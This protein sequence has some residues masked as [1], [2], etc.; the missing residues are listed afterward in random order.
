MITELKPYSE[1]TDSRVEWLGAGR[2]AV[3]Q[4]WLR[5]ATRLEQ[6]RPA[7]VPTVCP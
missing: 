7:C 4:L 6:T 3:G 1:Y 5:F 2:R